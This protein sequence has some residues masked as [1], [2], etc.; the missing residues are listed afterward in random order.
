M[1]AS[2]AAEAETGGLFTNMKEAVILRSKL[3]EMGHPQPATP[4]LV[5]N[6]TAC[7]IAND[8]IK[9]QRAKAIDM[10]FYWFRDRV[11][12]GQ[13]I[14]FWGPGARN[15]ADYFTKHHTAKHHQTMRPIYVQDM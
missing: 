8:N 6:S 14:V 5:D 12:Q 10:R 9:I 7:G 15:L 11:N 1:V 4:I 13:F 3:H 2:S